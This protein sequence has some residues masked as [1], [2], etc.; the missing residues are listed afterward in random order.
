MLIRGPGVEEEWEEGE[1]VGGVERR[2]K[3]RGKMGGRRWKWEGWK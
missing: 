2:W 3:K 1:G